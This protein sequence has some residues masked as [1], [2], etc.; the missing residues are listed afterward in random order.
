MLRGDLFEHTEVQI[1]R[2]DDLLDSNVLQV[3]GPLR[4]F[5]GQITIHRAAVLA[6]VNQHG[7]LKLVLPSGCTYKASSKYEMLPVLRPSARG[8]P[9]LRKL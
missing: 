6:R 7:N 3:K 1:S 5:S 8:K 2:L 4:L 9:G